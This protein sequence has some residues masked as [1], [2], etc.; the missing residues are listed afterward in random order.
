MRLKNIKFIPVF[1]A[2]LKQKFLCFFVMLIPLLV[3]LVHV[4]DIYNHTCLFYSVTRIPCH[5]CGLTRA[6]S[7]TLAGDWTAA[8]QFH[9]LIPLL[10]LF[11]IIILLIT[12]LPQKFRS[13]IIRRVEAF[14]LKTCFFFWFLVIYF[15]YGIARIT[16]LAYNLY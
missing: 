12:V 7:H 15:G 2:I 13:L 3:L 10:L 6:L 1:S 11:W 16:I 5:S 8:M 9:L 4:L 14:E